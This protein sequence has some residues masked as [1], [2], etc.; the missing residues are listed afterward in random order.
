MSEEPRP[1]ATLEDVWRERD[2]WAL[3]ARKAKKRQT[4]TRLAALSL[5][6]T[7]ALFGT[8]A[9][10]VAGYALVPPWDQASSVLG[11]LSAIMIALGGYLGRELLTPD[12]E[13]GWARARLLAEALQQECWRYQMRVPPYDGFRA[14]E[15]LRAR[16][17]E[18]TRNRGLERPPVK[19]DEEVEPPTPS[20]VRTLHL[21]TRPENNDRRQDTGQRSDRM[22]DNQ[23]RYLYR[24]L[25]EHGYEGEQATFMLCE[26][27]GVG[28]IADITKIR[29]SQLIDT[30][31]KEVAGA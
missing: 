16:A 25:S 22:S 2:A 14:H 5:G 26:S 13:T 29:A 31:K 8:I 9:G 6:F 27:A 24:L 23:R 20:N 28:S 17:E 19:M 30:W 10:F 15:A 21:R 11:I 1:R 18:M 4:K 12:R 7:G 3:E